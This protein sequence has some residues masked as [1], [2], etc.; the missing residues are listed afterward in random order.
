M[1]ASLPVVLAGDVAVGMTSLVNFAGSASPDV[2]FPAIAKEAPLADCAGVASPD[3][4]AMA[5]PSTVAE[6]ASATDIAGVTTPSTIAE[7]TS[8]ADIAGVASPAVAEVASSA[9]IAGTASPAIAGVASSA[10]GVEVEEVEESSADPVGDVSFSGMNDMKCENDWLSDSTSPNIYLPD[11][12]YPDN[13]SP[14]RIRRE[15]DPESVRTPG[16]VAVL[17]HGF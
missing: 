17:P 2:V 1:G 6:V 4:C 7:V 3:D 16:R 10:I 14:S 11:I 15:S 12:D 9:D 13:N 5:V 8:S